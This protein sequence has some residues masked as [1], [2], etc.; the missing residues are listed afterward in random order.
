MRIAIAIAIAMSHLD[1]PVGQLARGLQ[2]HEMPPLR[3]IPERDHRDATAPAEGLT[4]AI[5]IDH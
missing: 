2:P 4:R 5:A 1:I 3:A